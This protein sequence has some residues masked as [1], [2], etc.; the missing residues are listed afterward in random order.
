MEGY[1]AAPDLLSFGDPIKT[2]GI[3]SEYPVH[4]FNKYFLSSCSMPGTGLVN[5]VTTVNKKKFL[6]SW[7]LQFSPD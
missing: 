6:L 4:L 5:E 1:L 3:L 7:N 2:D